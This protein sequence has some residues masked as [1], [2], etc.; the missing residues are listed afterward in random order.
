M[1]HLHTS[2]GNAV[3]SQ[4]VFW[5]DVALLVILGGLHTLAWIVEKPTPAR[6]GEAAATR[7][8]MATTG[9]LTVAGF[10]VPLTI[11]ALTAQGTKTPIPGGVF[12]DFL[13]A[14]VLFFCSL[15]AG[16]IVLYLSFYNQNILSNKPINIFAGYQLFLLLVGGFQLIWGFGRLVQGYLA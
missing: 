12:V 4:A 6:S 9:G 10:L 3:T 13:I 1:G 11:V 8:Q 14:D 2:L 16:L 15:V 5:I 7:L